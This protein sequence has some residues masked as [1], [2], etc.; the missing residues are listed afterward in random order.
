MPENEG[1]E[2]IPSDCE[3]IRLVKYQSAIRTDAITTPTRRVRRGDE[4]NAWSS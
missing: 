2:R 1:Y 4:V 3:E